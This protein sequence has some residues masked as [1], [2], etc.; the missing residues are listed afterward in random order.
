MA[1]IDLY[2]TWRATVP[3]ILRA[4]AQLR[5]LSHA[6]NTAYASHFSHTQKM[7]NLNLLLQVTDITL[8]GKRIPGGNLSQRRRYV[9]TTCPGPFLYHSS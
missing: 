7:G 9:T 4:A 6:H 2:N 3:R 8:N 5:R 1:D